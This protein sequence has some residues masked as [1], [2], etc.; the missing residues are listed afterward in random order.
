LDRKIYRK[1]HEKRPN[2]SWN[3]DLGF[4]V[5][6]ARDLV[7]TMKTQ[8]DSTQ[9]IPTVGSEFALKMP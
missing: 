3:E 8:P 4:E 9:V 6:E 7:D 2:S 1:G 5:L